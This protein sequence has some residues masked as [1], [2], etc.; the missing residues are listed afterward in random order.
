MGFDSIDNMISEVSGGKFWRADFM[1][2]VGGV[3]TVV[4]GRWYDLSQL[5]LTSSVWNFVHG[6]YVRNHD[7]LSGSA[8]WTLGSANWAWTPA[9]HLL[10]RTAN[11]DCS[12]VSQNTACVNGTSYSVVFTLTRSAGSITVSLGGTAGTARSTSATFR[13][14]IACGA[15]AN[16]PLVFTPDATFAG[17]LDVVAVTRDLAFTPYDEDNTYS[18]GDAN[19]VWHGGD[20][21]TETKHIMN[22]GAW[23]NLA[24]SAPATLLLVDMLGCYP[25]IPT[26]SSALQT[27]NN[28]LTLPRYT[29]GKNVMAFLQLNTAN[30]T[31][32]QNTTMLYTNT[33]D[34]SGRGLG[35]TVANTVSAIV[36]HIFH[37]G[38][39]AYNTGPFLPMTG[40]DQ[41]VKSVQ[42][43]QFSAASASAGFV[44]L[45][46]CK[47]LAEIPLTA[48]FYTNE[49]DFL[50]Q[51]P[52]LPR[53][54][55]GACL[56]LIV[57][58][59]AVMAASVYQGYIDFAWS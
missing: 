52:S 7:F 41:G 27:L 51:L 58:C 45:V 54:Y 28:T 42:S 48:A 46:L 23:T 38:A 1:K 22:M 32:A 10:T 39:A 25:R 18:G 15:T 55:D 50:N 59:G 20:V 6:N 9:T 49:R 8:F 12:T 11:A 2:N 53:V 21:S 36:G 34:V 29:D 57:G 44:D 56:S 4:A 14:T 33:A 17:T 30:G 37:S 43:V 47:V 40:G 24:A 3:G 5:P 31:T 19:L 26:N 16:A 13:E 35:T